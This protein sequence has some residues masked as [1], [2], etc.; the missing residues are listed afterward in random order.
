M[1]AQLLT[2]GHPA[3][4]GVLFTVTVS[5]SA[6]PVPGSGGGGQAS[7]DPTIFHTR[8]LCPQNRSSHVTHP[9]TPWPWCWG[10][11][12]WPECRAL[13]LP[14]GEAP[15]PYVLPLPASGR[16]HGNGGVGERA[17]GAPLGVS[18]RLCLAGAREPP[19]EAGPWGKASWRYPTE[20]PF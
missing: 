20:C 6:C 14:Q 5:L 18:C 16:A 3:V 9:H 1:E 13:S 10:Y 8:T 7:A 12:L 2:E 11:C 15:T 4:L 17:S 19:P